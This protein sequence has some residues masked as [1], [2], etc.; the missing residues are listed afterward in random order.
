[1]TAAARDAKVQD[2]RAA[3]GFTLLEVLFV[4]VLIALFGGVAIYCMRGGTS[5]PHRCEPDIEEI[6]TRLQI[7]QS[8]GGVLPNTQQGLQAL[9]TR[10]AGE[11]QPRSWEKLLPENP[12]DPW[13][14]EYQYR[15][16]GTRS[17]DSF[18]IFS[19]GK[20]KIPDTGDDVG[21]W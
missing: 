12:V 8:K 3:G 1:M 5:C 18:E 17:K 13:R 20:D 16:P 19:C 6:K 10:P 4:L 11:P 2:G 21:N 14:T 7:Y 9:V 15:C